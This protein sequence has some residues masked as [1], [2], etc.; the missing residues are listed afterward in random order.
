MDMQIEKIRIKDVIIDDSP[1]SL[2]SLFTD[3]DPEQNRLSDS[4]KSLGIIYPIVIYR[5][6]ENRLHL[7]DGKKRLQFAKE[8]N[9][10]IIK[11][12]ILPT[13]TPETDIIHLIYCIRKPEIEKSVMNKVQ[14]IN[15]VLTFDIPELWIFSS[16][17]KPLGLK[18]HIE[19]LDECMMINKLPE[20]LKLFCHE[21]G[22]SLKQITNL[23]HHSTDILDQLVNWNSLLQLSASTL[24]EIASNLSA[25]LKREN[26]NITDFIAEPAVSE[27]ID[28]SDSARQKTERLRRFLYLR[29]YPMLSE[30]N[31]RIRRRIE[32]L[33]LP[34]EITIGWDET[35]ENKFL[36]LSINLKE[37]ERWKELLNDLES[38]EIGAVINEVLDEL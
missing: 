32:E 36:N 37:P 35:L 24:D 16:L 38:E 22:F 34:G 20:D 7:I 2:K 6:N 1:Y 3:S 28:S 13:S 14:F 30:V 31:D 8:S 17:C 26:R 29:N 10:D 5:D 12:S 18:A 25:C 23:S 27:I 9:E 19:L 21:K 15:F 11:A 33:K 4:F